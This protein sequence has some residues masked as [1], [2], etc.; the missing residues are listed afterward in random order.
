M[1]KEGI[2]IYACP[3]RALALEPLGHHQLEFQ[4][5]RLQWV[6]RMV[7]LCGTGGLRSALQFKQRNGP[8]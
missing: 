1:E 8:N 6:K 5:G 4:D 2:S 7:M 3:E